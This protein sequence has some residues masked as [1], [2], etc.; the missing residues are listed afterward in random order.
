[1]H[2]LIRMDIRTM[3]MKFMMLHN[4]IMDTALM[5]FMV[6][7]NKIMNMMLMKFMVLQ[8]KDIRIRNLQN[9]KLLAT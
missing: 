4:K 1:M 7:H 6:W 5:K 3:L 2:M 8:N 9:V